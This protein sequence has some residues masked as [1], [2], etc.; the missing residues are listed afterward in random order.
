MS[1]NGAN[2]SFDDIK[3]DF[4]DV[5]IVPSD[6]STV[7]SRSDVNL[8]RSFPKLNLG[9]VPIMAANMDT[10]GTFEMAKALS[11]QKMLTALHKHYDSNDII[12]FFNENPSCIQFTA[13]SSGIQDADFE[14]LVRISKTISLK[15]ICIDAANG[16]LKVF[17][18]YITRVRKEFPCTIIIA[19]NAVTPTACMEIIRSGANIV[20][21]GIGSGSVCTTRLMT[22]VGYPQL[23][24]I[25]ECKQK[26]HAVGGLLM[27]DGGC[28]HAGDISKAF[29]AGA[30]FVMLGGMLSGH[31]ECSGTVI[32]IG[33]KYKMEFY[34]MSSSTA[35]VKHYGEVASY[36]ASEGKR[37]L[38]DYRG[39]VLSTIQSI[40]G[41]IRSTCT[42]INVNKIQEMSY[43]ANFI[44]VL[45]QVNTVFGEKS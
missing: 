17:N 27:S 25:L 32:Q 19:G 28:V 43:N 1:S 37:V 40:L 14:K 6:E 30:D 35:M 31:D 29:C 11:S 33:D 21:V 44:R 26:V 12:T 22:G 41:G 38:V 9:C 7:N 45:H 20:K 4:S 16:H 10:T 3:L 23:S 42:Y 34:G 5:L 18:E 24:A 2:V 39:P 8:V 15:L 13:V 36:R